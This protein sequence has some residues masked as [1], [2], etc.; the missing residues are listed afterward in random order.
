MTGGSST[1]A[2]EAWP[3]TPDT[4]RLPGRPRSL[5]VPVGQG[6]RD[7]RSFGTA[8]HARPLNDPP[9]QGDCAAYGHA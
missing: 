9:G 8:P 7:V 4:C 6:D 2:G 3:P 5:A 1:T